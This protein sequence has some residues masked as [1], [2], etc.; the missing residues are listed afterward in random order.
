MP[1]RRKTS[2]CLDPLLTPGQRVNSLEQAYHLAVLL[3]GLSLLTFLVMRGHSIFVAAPL[4]ALV[5]LTLSGADPV[6]G[7]TTDFMRG[8]SKFV[9]DFYLIF[10]LGAAFGKLMDDSGAAVTIARWV[11]RRIGAHRACLAVVLACAVLTYGGVSLFVVGFSVYPLA[12]RLFREANLPRRFIPGAIAFGSVTFTM[13]SAGSP[14][15]QNL[16]PIKHLVDAKTGLPLTDAQAGWPV[17]LIVAS[18][19]F[20]IGQWYLE[21]AIRADQAEGEGFQPHPGDEPIED[22][23][24]SR[25]F[26]SVI[27]ASAAGR[28]RWLHLNVAPKLVPR[29]PEDPTLAIFSGVVVAIL[30]LWPC[31]KSVWS[32]LGQGFTNGLL[33]LGSTCSVVG[34]GTAVQTLPAFKQVVDWVT[35]LPTDPLIGAALAVAVIAGIAGS[36]S[37]GQGIALPLIKGIYIDELG[38]APRALHRVVSIA[39]GSLD[40]LPANGYIVL[41]IRN[42]CGETHRRAS[43]D[44]SSSP[45]CWCRF[46][47]P[48]SPS[49]FFSS[50]RVGPRC[51]VD[52]L[53]TTGTSI[54]LTAG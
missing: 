46:S 27:V 3:G 5:T 53:N 43:T 14:E 31:L 41:L 21:R 12:V 54:S 44:R 51:D 36:A 42:I 49:P 47:A 10:V 19:M 40:S 22:A 32:P 11:V 23:S 38:V 30:C 13:T 25:R 7:M 17:S 26:P 4:C 6:A 50:S 8:F 28:R 15:I 16:I 39:S 29:F 37:G 35:H 34:F 20:L 18:L 33:A 1:I 52:Y 48:P 45:P 2:L 9:G 24:E